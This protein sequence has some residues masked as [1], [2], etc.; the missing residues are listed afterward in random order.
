MEKYTTYKESGIEWIGAI[1][2]HWSTSNMRWVTSI[3][4]GGTPSKDKPEYWEDGTIP[5]LNSGSVNQ[6][7]IIVPSKYISEEGFN[8]SSARW[9]PR[10]SVVMALAGQG[11][12][13]GTAAYLDIESTCNQSMAAICPF[14]D[15][16]SKFLYFYLKSKYQSIRG[17]AGDGKRDGLN[18]EMI[19]QIPCPIPSLHEQTAIASFLDRKTKLIDDLIAKKERLIELKKEERAAI[20]NR[21]VTKGLDPNVPMKDSGI[22]WLGE[23][24]EGWEVKKLKYL[25]EGTLK[26]GAN[27]SGIEES[28]GNIRYVRITDFDED[29]NL[30]PENCKFLD[31]EKSKEYLLED[32]DVLFA[33][34]G[35]TVGKTFQFKNVNIIACF[36]GYL[37]SARPNTEVLATD[38]LYYYTKT[39][40]YLNWKNSVFIQATIQN[41]GADKYSNLVL[42]VPPREEQI[43]ITQYIIDRY[44]SIE[45]QLIRYQKQID[46]LK[47]YKT[48]LISEAVTGKIRI[49]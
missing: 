30:R 9:I 43:V 12:T 19:A 46:L 5:W 45:E 26:Y 48:T 44:K 39:G 32:G 11:K 1:P 2:K 29:G 16:Y 22:E 42:P 15:S 27:E 40:S 6:G 13:K 38:Y 21:S 34:S 37:I 18:L 28:E 20:I 8:N 31:P 36:A 41:I 49:A 24:P 7:I 33:R 3:F 4:A 17:L 14:Q 47:E 23:V 25:I 35:A 10:G